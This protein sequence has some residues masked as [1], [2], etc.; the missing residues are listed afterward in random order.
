METKHNHQLH[1]EQSRPDDRNLRIDKVGVRDLRFPIR[2]RDKA[3]EHQDT[4][5]TI[6]M[7]VD[8][9]HNFKGTH[10]SRFIEVLN[11]HG[12][13]MH[14]ENIPD[15]LQA[16][17]QALGNKA[18]ISRFGSAYIPM[19]ETLARA[20]VDFSG[21]PYLVFNAAFDEEMIG[22]FPSALAEEFFRSLVDHSR[23]NLHV[24]L[25]RGSNAHHSVEA[26]FKAVARAIRA[27]IAIDP[28]VKGIPSTK[29]V[30]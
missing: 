4:I 8:L 16:M 12:N 30:L 10:M 27:A 23:I 26:I 11:A 14:V 7:Y 29:G 5:A 22:T 19:D 1:D 18:G 21:R 20:A 15:I 17:Q 24:D 2:I 25:I 3:N 28:S 13:V 9:P 6:G